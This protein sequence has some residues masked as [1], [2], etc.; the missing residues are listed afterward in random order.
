LAD[1]LNLP[2]NSLKENYN[3][4]SQNSGGNGHF[5]AAGRFGKIGTNISLS[6]Q[7]NDTE[8][9]FLLWRP[10]LRHPTHKMLFTA[11]RMFM[12]TVENEYIQNIERRKTRFELMANGSVIVE[13]LLNDKYRLKKMLRRY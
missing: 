1:L 13:D 12:V 4:G 9:F 2:L 3:F 8:T 5:K 11:L 7:M 10:E 6:F